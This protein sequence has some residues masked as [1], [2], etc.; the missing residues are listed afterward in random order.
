LGI[1]HRLL[2]GG[3]PAVALPAMNP[4]RD[5]I[6]EI[7]R[8]GVNL[9]GAGTVQRLERA[10]RRGELHAVVGGD[11][12][13]AGEL[14]APAIEFEDRSPPA[15]PRVSRTGAVGVNDDPIPAHAAGLI[16]RSDRGSLN[17]I[18]SSR[19]VAVSMR[20]SNR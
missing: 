18:V 14:L 7:V 3:L 11:R 2:V 19:S 5:S 20:T 1:L 17:D 8:I 4:L 9:D 10:D 13:A 12:L 6:L 16:S 15:G